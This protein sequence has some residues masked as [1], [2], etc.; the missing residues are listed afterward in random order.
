AT[1]LLGL[2]VEVFGGGDARRDRL[3]NGQCGVREL[4]IVVWV[5]RGSA[6]HAIWVCAIL[7]TAWQSSSAF[8]GRAPI[9]VHERQL[10]PVTRSVIALRVPPGGRSLFCVGAL[11]RYQRRRCRLREAPPVCSGVGLNQRD[12]VNQGR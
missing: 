5:Q 12:R 2:L 3:A 6:G 11:L 1:A 4:R 9:P 8:R 7:R 10:V